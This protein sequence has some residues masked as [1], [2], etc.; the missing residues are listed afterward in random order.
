[1]IGLSYRW[2]YLTT[3]NKGYYRFDN[4]FHTIS[5]DFMFKLN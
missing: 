5:L 4:A 2:D 1:M 3:R